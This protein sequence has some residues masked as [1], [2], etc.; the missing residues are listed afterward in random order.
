MEISPGKAFTGMIKIDG[1]YDITDLYT[2]MTDSR[3]GE[4]L[5]SYKPVKHQKAD[6]LPD[7]VRRP[8]AAKRY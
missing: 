4:V 2:E 3:T 8:A 1:S 5:V 7:I 6:K